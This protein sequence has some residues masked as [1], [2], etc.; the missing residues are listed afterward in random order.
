MHSIEIPTKLGAGT[1][2]VQI[3]RKASQGGYTDLQRGDG[4]SGG[5]EALKLHTIP[6]G[7]TGPGLATT[8]L[9]GTLH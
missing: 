8:G 6:V 4:R 3:Q 1:E 9:P 5:G 2:A 7:M